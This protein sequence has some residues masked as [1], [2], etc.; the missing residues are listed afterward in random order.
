MASWRHRAVTLSMVAMGSMAQYDCDPMA[1]PATRLERCLERAVAKMTRVGEVAHVECDLKLKGRFTVVLHPANELNNDELVWGGLPESLVPELR[2]LRQRRGPAMYVIATDPHIKGVGIGRTIL[3][4][5][6]TNQS[7]FVE[8]PQLM[9]LTRS[10]QPLTI[11][12]GKTRETNVIR[13]IR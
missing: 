7:T 11:E 2:T 8:I 9:V 13:R 12:V 4:S 6:S 5:R 10:S 1:E 3:S